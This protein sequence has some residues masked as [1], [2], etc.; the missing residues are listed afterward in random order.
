MDRLAGVNIYTRGDTF[1]A[2]GDTIQ[3]NYLH[4]FQSEAEVNATLVKGGWR[5]ADSKLQ[6]LWW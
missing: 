2:K 5:A 4:V 3:P 1:R 6:P